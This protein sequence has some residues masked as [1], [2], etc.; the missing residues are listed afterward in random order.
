MRYYETRTWEHEQDLNEKNRAQKNASQ[1]KIK[2]L[3]LRAEMR[4]LIKSNN[5]PI[6]KEIAILLGIKQQP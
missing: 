3:N 1:Y 5:I 6:T 4:E 2:Y